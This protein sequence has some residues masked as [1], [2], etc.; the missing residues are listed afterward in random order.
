MKHTTYA[1]EWKSHK[2]NNIRAIDA[3]HWL[4]CYTVSVGADAYQCR[5]QPIGKTDKTPA[6]RQPGG[7]FIVYIEML[8]EIV[9]SSGFGTYF[10]FYGLYAMETIKALESVGSEISLDL[11][12]QA[13]DKIPID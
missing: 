6:R 10:A 11:L 2:Q 3:I 4:G 1:T 5:R 9:N 7:F 8:E 13:I 12:K